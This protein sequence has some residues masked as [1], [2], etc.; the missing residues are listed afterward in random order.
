M[1]EL[2]LQHAALNFVVT[3]HHIVSSLFQPKKNNSTFLRTEAL[4][5][6]TAPSDCPA[7]ELASD[8][9]KEW[10]KV[11]PHRSHRIRRAIADELPGATSKHVAVVR[12]ILPGF[13][14]RLLFVPTKPLPPGEGPE[15]IAQALFNRFTKPPE[16]FSP[17]FRMDGRDRLR[18]RD[19]HDVQ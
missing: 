2:P 8:L 15:W 7:W 4:M 14:I 10:S 6:K 19:R 1:I 12:Q 17:S 9:D 13:R 16:T 11:N 18:H 5:K 3:A